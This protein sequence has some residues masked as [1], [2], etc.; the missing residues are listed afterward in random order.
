[1]IYK[2]HLAIV[3][4]SAGIVGTNGCVN[5]GKAKFGRYGVGGGKQRGSNAAFGAANFAKGRNDAERFWQAFIIFKRLVAKQAT[6]YFGGVR[7]G[8][9]ANYHLHFPQKLIVACGEILAD[10]QGRPQMDAQPLYYVWSRLAEQFV[11]LTHGK[12][13]DLGRL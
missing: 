6:G 5:F 13:C 12:S 2:P 7:N 11:R 9:G 8:G 10:S 3:G 4:Q 1:M